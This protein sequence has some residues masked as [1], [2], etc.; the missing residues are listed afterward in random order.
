MYLSEVRY[1]FFRL[2]PRRR[3]ATPFPSLAGVSFF[4]WSLDFVFCPA[5]VT[6]RMALSSKQISSTSH[7]SIEMP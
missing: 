2:N 5:R 6:A 7:V 1:P 3:D 4:N